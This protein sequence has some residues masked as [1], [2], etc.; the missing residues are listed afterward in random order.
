VWGIIDKK[1]SYFTKGKRR[2]LGM[3]ALGTTNSVDDKSI[4]SDV[5]G[6]TIIAG[7]GIHRNR[8]FFAKDRNR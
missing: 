4:V 1:R 7:R 2:N 3:V 5:L 8:G 6:N